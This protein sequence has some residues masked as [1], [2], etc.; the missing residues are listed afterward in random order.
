MIATSV[1]PTPATRRQA[2]CT[3]TIPTRATTATRVL[4]TTPVPTE[5]A[6]VGLRPTA[7]TATC[8]RPTPA[9]PRRVAC[10]PTTPTP[11]TTATRVLQTTPVPTEHAWVGLR[12]TATMATSARPTPATPRR[13]ACTPTTPTPA[14][15]AMPA[16]QVTLAAEERVM[17]GHPWCATTTMC[18]RMTPVTRPQGAS[19]P[20]ARQTTR[21]D[22]R[23]RRTSYAA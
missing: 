21:L 23:H 10:T 1:R 17:R 3:P 9:T 22:S 15:T 18:V 14:T 5:H 12:P 13:V 16:P 20:T 7:T 8:A 19:L 2:A 6:W 4:P 11:A